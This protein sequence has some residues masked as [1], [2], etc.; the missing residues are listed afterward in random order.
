MGF[1]ASGATFLRV[2]FLAGVTDNTDTC[3]SIPRAC[4]ICH[5]FLATP[6]GAVL[7]RLRWCSEHF[8][9][10]VEKIGHR[11]AAA[12]KPCWHH[13]VSDALTRPATVRR[14][15]SVLAELTLKSFNKS[16]KRRE[17][18][19]LS[20]RPQRGGQPSPKVHQTHITIN[21]PAF[22]KFLVG[23]SDDRDI[24]PCKVT[25]NRISTFAC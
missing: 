16:L 22:N 20:Y 11:H 18:M 9:S 7:P 3:C 25:T 17:A 21:P 14:H 12:R 6:L 2:L 10:I 8:A 5:S 15:I 1:L 13:T 24:V 19:M 23:A 4:G